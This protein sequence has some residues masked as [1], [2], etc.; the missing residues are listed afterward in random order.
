MLL[1]G[2]VDTGSSDVIVNAAEVGVGKPESLD[3][4]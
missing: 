4:Y 3:A 1:V 2:S